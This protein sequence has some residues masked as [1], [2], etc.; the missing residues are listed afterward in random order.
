MQ[1]CA[2]HIVS[3]LI[4]GALQ[5]LVIRDQMFDLM[6]ANGLPVDASFYAEKDAEKVQLLAITKDPSTGTGYRVRV[7]VGV[8]D[9]VG[10]FGPYYRCG[11]A[12]TLAQ[13]VS[14]LSRNYSS[15]QEQASVS[16]KTRSSGYLA[17]KT[18]HHGSHLT[19]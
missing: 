11:S 18:M 10:F 15:L 6:A 3:S 2:G 1:L 12:I 8:T 9:T 17:A 13:A 7:P 14:I 5:A 16:W 19:L 4:I